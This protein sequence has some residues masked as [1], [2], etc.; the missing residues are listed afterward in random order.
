MALA[1]GGLQN[2][3]DRANLIAYLASMAPASSPALIPPVQEAN[4]QAPSTPAAAPP[5]ATA[6]PQVVIATPA[7]EAPLPAD[8]TKR[9]ALVIGNAGYRNVNPLK[10]PD[11]DAHAIAE[12]LRKLGFAEV[13][14]KHDVSL[15][16]LSATLKD[17]GD[18]AQDADW[19]VIYYAGH[20]IEVG[21]VNY[22]I[23]VDAEL[24]TSSH[25]EEEAIPL[26][27][28]LSKVE[29]AKKL[30][31]V[32]L[33]ACRDNPFAQ[34]IAS[35]G[36]TRSVGRGLGRVEPSG[37]IMVAYSA[38]DGHV[39]QDGDAANSPFAEALLENL[40]QPGIEIGLL[41]RKVHDSVMSKTRGEQEPFTY[42]ALPAEALYFKTAGQ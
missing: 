5:S 19:A 32:I 41:F 26:E 42:G 3:Q 10:N 29:G 17:F 27:R 31:L 40:D 24:K 36:G 14:E 4:A 37:G 13:I 8:Q 15:S 11:A 12:S 2:R 22:V 30:R 18:K 16:D 23:P 25:V 7:P 39:A 34:R 35:A 9:I 33:D 6:K 38:R 21:G 20:G 1:M 28:V